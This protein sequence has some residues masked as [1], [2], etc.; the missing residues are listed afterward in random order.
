MSNTRSPA[1]GPA[2]I[3]PSASDV[4]TIESTLRYAETWLKSESGGSM[5]LDQ[6]IATC[7]ASALQRLAP[8]LKTAVAFVDEQGKRVDVDRGYT[9]GLPE[10]F[11]ATEFEALV[12]AVEGAGR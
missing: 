8:V 1:T 2:E 11:A 9:I 6:F 3:R 5:T 4:P 12:R 10:D 7:F